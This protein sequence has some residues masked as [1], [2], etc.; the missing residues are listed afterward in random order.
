M[1]ILVSCSRDTASYDMAEARLTLSTGTMSVT[2]TT[3]P[4]EERITDLNIF[5]FDENGSLERHVFLGRNSLPSTKT[6]L[7]TGSLGS[8]ARNVRSMHA[9]ISDST[10]WASV[11][12]K[13]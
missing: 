4:D 8:A 3:D 11:P 1:S 10:L 9:P 2:R 7:N 13:T 6:A 5:I 12:R